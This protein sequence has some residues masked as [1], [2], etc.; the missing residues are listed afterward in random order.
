LRIT[1]MG[2]GGLGGFLG[3]RLASIG[4]QVTFIARGENLKVLRAHGIRLEE[5]ASDV[6]LDS[7]LATDDPLAAGPADVVI[8]GV[9]SWQVA[10]TAPLLKPLVS[11]RTVV[12]A[13]QNGV[14]AV[15]QLAGVLGE[16]HVLGGACAITSY[17][18]GP[19]HVYHF[20]GRPWM[21]LGRIVSV[22]D[23]IDTVVEQLREALC[24]AA[25]QCTC[26]SD[27][28]RSIWRKFLLITSYGGIGAV[29]RMP[30]GVTRSLAQTR[31]LIEE[32]M[33]EVLL[34]GR[35][36]NVALDEGDVQA[37]MRQFDELPPDATTSMQRDIAAGRRSELPD[38][39][40]AVVR[41]AAQVDVV[42]RIHQFIYWLLLPSELRA[43]G[44]LGG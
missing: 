28:R 9:K 23:S 42:P 36:H 43:V 19:G 35:R 6:V 32:A 41:L 38:L 22:P 25:V 4:H 27:I 29:T 26:S 10:E 44:E 33:N 11:D 2:A 17:L 8:V 7:V 14:E 13:I 37:M 5:P 24:L 30:V 3:A 18:V 20:G 40:G 21:T 16:H 15:D 31:Q 1:V 12:L 39:N 34:V